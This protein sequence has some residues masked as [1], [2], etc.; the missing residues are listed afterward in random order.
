[1]HM[2]WVEIT[3]HTTTE[4]ADIVS[5]QLMQE[6]ATGT[7]V[8]DRADIPDP[9]KPNGFWEMIDQKLIDDMPEDV[10]VHA[11]FEPDER[12]ADRMGALN[13]RMAELRAL[14]L[15]FSLGSLDIA[16]QNVRD[17]D[18][19]EV[20][21]KFYKPFRAG[22]TMVV[23]PTWEAYEPQEGD[24]IIEI[25]PGMAFGSGTHETTS[26]CLD[27]LEEVITGGET[28]IDVGT[29]SGIL[30]IGAAMLGARDVLAID[31]DE[32]AVKVAQENIEHNG[33]TDR[34]TAVQ[35]NL[36]EK[37]DADCDICVANIIADVI[38]FFAEPL[39]HHIVPGGRFI[40]SGII[41]EREGDVT[42]ALLAAGYEIEKICR[43]GEWVA[44]L[45]RR[46]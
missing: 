24:K 40:C 35:G 3:V 23:K 25:D 22:R 42:A 8:E 10:L 29:G 12:F 15:P 28:V 6:G 27:L 46:A 26:M 19:S 5:E 39:T 11:W 1:N 17:E 43:K 36:L 31:I 44:M 37:T 9:S 32:V 41:K 21:K 7:M 30:A 14:G 2:D 38:C 18:W 45:S 13:A 16:T 4:G 20:W 33:L 34:I